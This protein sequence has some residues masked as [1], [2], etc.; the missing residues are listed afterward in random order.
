MD[1]YIDSE[2]ISFTPGRLVSTGYASPYGDS[3][4]L[5]Y[6]NDHYLGSIISPGKEE[7]QKLVFLLLKGKKGG[8]K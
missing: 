4:V 6:E 1:I 8:K 5:F 2:K 3:E 7:F